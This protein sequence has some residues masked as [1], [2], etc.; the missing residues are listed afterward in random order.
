M[1]YKKVIFSSFHEVS[2]MDKMLMQTL[3]EQGFGE[4]TIKHTQEEGSLFLD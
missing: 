2:Q 4:K 1:G 3:C